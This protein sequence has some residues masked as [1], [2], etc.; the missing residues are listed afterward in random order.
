[1]GWEKFD[2]GLKNIKRSYLCRCLGRTR[3]EDIKRTEI[4]LE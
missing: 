3:K 2:K 1:M 4:G